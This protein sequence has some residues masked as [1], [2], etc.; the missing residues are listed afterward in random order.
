ME[1]RSMQKTTMSTL[2]WT[3]CPATVWQETESCRLQVACEVDSSREVFHNGT[4]TNLLTLELE[5]QMT[6]KLSECKIC[7]VQSVSVCMCVCVCHCLSDICTATFSK[8][9]IHH[10]VVMSS[11]GMMCR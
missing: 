7:D 10:F 4:L 1:Q 6:V 2:Q 3:V 9:L 8:C 11:C 5:R